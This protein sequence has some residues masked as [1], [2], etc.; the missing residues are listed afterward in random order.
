MS[1]TLGLF[2][3]Y[4]AK[5]I[6]LFNFFFVWGF[7]CRSLVF[8]LLCV[9]TVDYFSSGD[10]LS[11][12][13]LQIGGWGG[14]L[15]PCWQCCSNRCLHLQSQI[16]SGFTRGLCSPDQAH[17]WSFPA[18][19]TFISSV[20]SWFHPAHPWAAASI[21]QS[22]STLGSTWAI[23]FVQFFPPLKL[24]LARLFL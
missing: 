6:N 7:R 5:V 17:V 13:A 3:E 12:A 10:L 9:L 11:G 2:R 19:T 18:T 20:E 1:L 8:L 21:A 14:S 16:V 22:A 24:G 23:W 15:L 4:L